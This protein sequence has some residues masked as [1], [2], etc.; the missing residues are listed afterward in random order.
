MISSPPCCERLSGAK[1]QGSTRIKMFFKNQSIIKMH[2]A[3]FDGL[4]NIFAIDREA[5]AIS[6]ANRLF[7]SRPATAVFP[8]FMPGP[9]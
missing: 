6:D 4:Y 5:L 8:G 9:H 7:S 1:M 3:M 2:F